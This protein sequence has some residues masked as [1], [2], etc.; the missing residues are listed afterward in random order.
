MLFSLVRSARTS[1]SPDT[2]MFLIGAAVVSLVGF[3]CDKNPAAPDPLSI[4][5][6]GDSVVM[7]HDTLS[8]RVSVPDAATRGVRYIW[9]FDNQTTPDTTGDS[10]Y[11]RIC[12]VADTGNHCA[13]VKALDRDGTLSPTDSI[14]FRVAYQKPFFM[15]A[16]DLFGWVSVPCTV[17]F[18]ARKGSSSID[19]L[20][21]YRNDPQSVKATIDSVAIWTWKISDT[22][23][24]KIVAWAMDRDSLRSQRDSITVSVSA[25]RPVLR[26]LRDTSIKINDTL[27]ITL[28]AYDQRLP[29]NGFTYFV[30]YADS[31]KVAIDSTIKI[32]WRLSDTGT[33]RL[34]VRAE[35]SALMSSASDTAV[36]TV[37]CRHPRVLLLADSITGIYDTCLFTAQANDSDG[38]VVE[39]QWS[40]DGAPW[41]IT[42]TSTLSW[43]FA[44]NK[45]SSHIVRAF[46]ADNDGLPSDTAMAVVRTSLMRPTVTLRPA[47]TAILA[48]R[49]ILLRAV[50][51]DTNGTISA[52]TWRVDGREVGQSRASDS[53][54]LSFSVSDSGKHSIV[55]SVLDNDSLE[56]FPD[57]TIVQVLPGTPV[58]HA[59]NDT[60]ISSLDSLPLTCTAVDSNG[61]IAMYLWDF[62]GSGWSDST[63]EPRFLLRYDGRRNVRILVAARDNDGLLAVDTVAVAFNRQPDSILIHSPEIPYDTCMLSIVAPVHELIFDYASIDP[64]NDS[65]VYTVSWGASPD[66]LTPVY[67]G[68]SQACTLAIKDEGIYSWRIVARDSWG[69]I[70]ERAGT[71]VALKEY[72]ICFIGHSIVAGYGGNDSVGGFRG[73]LLDSL[74]KTLRPTACL[75]AVGTRL[76]PHMSRSS[77]DDSSLAIS[78]T[79]AFDIYTLLNSEAAALS[80][81][82][83]VLLIGCN[84][85]FNST[86]R[87]YANLIM[88]IMVNR[89][90][91]ARIY[92]LNSP[93]LDT[94]FTVHAANLPGFNQF[95]ADSVAAKAARGAHTYL[96]DAYSTLTVNGKY[97]KPWYSDYVHPNQ[98]GYNRLSNAIYTIMK[99]SS[100]PAIPPEP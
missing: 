27:A 55:C 43:R 45:A 76:T 22:G 46:V 12:S 3:F 92:V 73:G 67:E 36:I 59:M 15:L 60:T 91:D 83:W 31:V 66:S 78:A 42:R 68:R 94:M 69:N 34:V 53:L 88:D 82:L 58:I 79:K 5:T 61:S 70:R 93:P 25:S 71:Y 19:R 16:A 48:H 7:I 21:W 26:P 96:V 20:F 49:N 75:K 28:S 41:I 10:T 13:I 64:D 87:Y 50:P 86:E 97:N 39:Y 8:F 99:S 2:A 44:G 52:I 18:I 90:S 84:G 6:Y 4:T 1:L 74:R 33:H 32:V 24:Q 89:N 17:Q 37:T 9:L 77:V 11:S 23:M 40:I 65:I 81:D 14:R 57:S 95:I 35:N 47:D 62:D 29:I 54:D 85:E 72:R 100:P 38:T 56:S 80:A 98:T 63:T 51:F 30:D